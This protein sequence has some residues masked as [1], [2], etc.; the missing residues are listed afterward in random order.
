MEKHLWRTVFLLGICIFFALVLKVTPLPYKLAVV[1][2]EWVCILVIY[3]IINKPHEFGVVFAWSVGLFQDWIELNVWG[4]HALA[5]TV[6]A[7][8]CLVSWQRIR[9][10]SIWQQAMWVFVL[11]GT[12][13]VIVSW[14]QGMAGYHSP[15]HQILLPT[16]TSALLWPLCSWLLRRM[17][18]KLHIMTTH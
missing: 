12:H 15:T 3:W 6:I 13:Q 10:Y 11:V 4:A 9:S 17:Q 1:R 8:I 14:V 16:L 18:Q 5:L 2:P 7:Y